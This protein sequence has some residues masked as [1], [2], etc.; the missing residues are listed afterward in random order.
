MPVKDINGIT[1]LDRD[2]HMRPETNMQSLASLW[3]IFV[4]Q[5]SIPAR[6]SDA[7]L[8]AVLDPF[9]KIQSERDVFDGGRNGVRVLLK[10]ARSSDNTQPQDRMIDLLAGTGA[11][12]SSDAHQQVV[13]DMIRGPVTFENAN[14][15]DFVIMKSTDTPTYNF[16]AAVEGRLQTLVHHLRDTVIPS[17]TAGTGANT[18]PFG[19]G[20]HLIR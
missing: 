9:A 14:L 4:R 8:A 10:A 15:E 2:E 1:L 11:A 3:Q 19:P 17:A 16:A 12:N 18:H 20:R 13:E 7:A 5:G 6:E